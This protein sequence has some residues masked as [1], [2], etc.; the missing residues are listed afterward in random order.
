M[1]IR[2]RIVF[3]SLILLISFLC[4]GAARGSEKPYSR[5][6]QDVASKYEIPASLIHAVIFVESNYAPSAVSEKGASGLMQL[7]PEMAK[8]YGVKDVF[9]PADNIEGGAKYLKDLIRLYDGK[10]DLV[11]AAYNAG[12]NAVKVFNGIPPFPETRVYIK[13]IQDLYSNVT[14]RNK[15]TIYKFRDRSGCLWFTTDRPTYLANKAD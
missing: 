9:D 4:P 2:M 8:T 14:I 11:L 10:T 1:A 12:Q 15:A 6:I 13:K 3:W 5:L 7:M